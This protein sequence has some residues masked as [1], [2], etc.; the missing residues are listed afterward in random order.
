MNNDE[1]QLN[2]WEFKKCGR[3]PSGNKVLTRGLCPVALEIAADGIHNGKNGGRCCWV[4]TN[5]VYEGNTG[6]FAWK[7]ADNAGNAISISLLRNQKSS[8]SR[9]D[10]VIFNKTY[11]KIMETFPPHQYL[12][13]TCQLH[14]FRNDYNSEPLLCL[15]II[16]PD[17]WSTQRWVSRSLPCS[18]PP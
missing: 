13:N 1:T 15:W 8:F 4:I 2:C 16:L 14:S 11:E 17:S 12:G 6:A 3:E 18:L 5:S 9:P 7:E 10:P